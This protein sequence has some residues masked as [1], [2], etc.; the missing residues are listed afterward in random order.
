MSRSPRAPSLPLS[1]PTMNRTE[2]AGLY[3]H[4]PFCKTKCPYCDFYSV[5]ETKHARDW[6]NAVL[7]EASRYAPEFP[8]FDSL[9]IGGGTPSLLGHA[10]MEAVVEGLYGIL[11]FDDATELT[12]ELNPDDVT[13]EKLVMYRSLGVNRISLGVQSFNE[14]EVRFLGRRHSARQARKAVRLVAEGGFA[15]FGIDLIYGLP[16]QTAKAWLKTLEEAL[17]CGPVHLSCYQLTVEG[18]TPFSRL[19]AEGDLTLPDDSR[20]AEFF[21]ST[22]KYLTGRGFIHYEVSN[23]AQGEESLSRHNVK[24]WRHTP[25]LGLGPAAH[26]FSGGRRW[27]NHRSVDDYLA[28]VDERSCAV[29]GSEVLSKEQMHLE[30]LLFGFRTQ[31]G[32]EAAQLPGDRCEK[33][34]EDLQ[35]KGFIEVREGRVRPTLKGYLFADRLPLMVSE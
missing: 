30:R 7:K 26:S 31:W 19:K 11:R 8:R 2:H 12:V 9:Y 21:L 20:Q 16:G 27:W 3:V 32:V 17:S 4:V 35:R 33:R 10:D 6:S 18:D 23:F 5:T 25:Y 15:R 13:K 24:Y 34:V 29:A 28:D 22:S 14:E 1:R